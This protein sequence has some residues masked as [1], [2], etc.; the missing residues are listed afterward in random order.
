MLSHG[1]SSNILKVDQMKV[2]GVERFGQ[3]ETTL[4]DSKK[5]DLSLV[6]DCGRVIRLFHAEGIENLYT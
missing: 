1:M 4:I 6:V 3:C 5:T 2:L